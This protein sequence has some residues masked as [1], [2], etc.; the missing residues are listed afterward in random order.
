MSASRIN[1]SYMGLVSLIFVFLLILPTA[2]RAELYGFA[3]ISNNSGVSGQMAAQLSL[4]VI[5]LGEPESGEPYK[6]KFIF[7][8]NIAPYAV[9]E[10]DVMDGSVTDVYFDDGA[11]LTLAEILDADS[12]PAY[13]GVYFSQYAKPRDLP[14]GNTLLPPFEVT[15][16]FSADSDS[17]IAING[18]NPGESLGI[19]FE[20]KD[21]QT[22][23]DVIAQIDLGFTNTDPDVTNLRIGLRVQSYGDDNEFSDGFIMTPI[24]GA[25]ILG[26]LGLG[27]AGIKLRKFA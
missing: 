18:V 17:P 14:G 5:D 15:A 2:T 3:P 8:N 27:V 16:D 25:V 7:N 6:V 9:P 26:I 24:P 20:L 12:A 11:L 10:A 22:F 1:K 19:V 4:G 23:A 21:G 13:P